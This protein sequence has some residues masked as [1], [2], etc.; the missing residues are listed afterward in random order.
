[1]PKILVVDDQPYILNVLSD[2]LF[3]QGYQ[4][5]LAES[6]EKAAQVVKGSEVQL[7]LIDL[8]LNGMDGIA[9]MQKINQINPQVLSI[10]ITGY[11][12]QE[13]SVQALKAG[14]YDYVT[15]PFKLEDL[16]KTIE[17]ALKEY[18]LRQEI[19][20]LKEKIRKMEEELRE[21]HSKNTKVLN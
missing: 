4:V 10:I 11:S 18:Q 7:A 3:K 21:Y 15:K 5:V 16:K 6:G 20:D 12:T 2:F 1:M 17:R 8:K 14:A 13:S 19:S 9:T